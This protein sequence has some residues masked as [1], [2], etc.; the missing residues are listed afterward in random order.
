MS[1]ITINTKRATGPLGFDGLSDNDLIRIAAQAIDYAGEISLKHSQTTTQVPVA[2]C[3]FGKHFRDV[4]TNNDHETTMANVIRD[5]R[6]SGSI[7]PSG[8]D[9]FTFEYDGMTFEVMTEDFYNGRVEAAMECAVEDA[10]YEVDNQFPVAGYLNNYI[11]FDEDL[12]RRDLQF[13]IE[14]MVSPYDGTVHEMYWAEYGSGRTCC[15]Y[16]NDASPD[17]VV[18][19]ETLFMIRED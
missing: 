11:K 10:R 12:F 16:A 3:V 9:L 6:E 2:Y 7:R 17:L 1:D 15:G 4:V 19:R 18:R 14:A 8:D 5:I 13:D